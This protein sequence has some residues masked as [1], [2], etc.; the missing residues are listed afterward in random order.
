MVLKFD[1]YKFETFNSH[2]VPVH[3]KNYPWANGYVYITI[4]IGVGARHDPIGGEGTAHHFEHMPFNGCAGWE[5]HKEVQRV[6]RELFSETLNASTSHEGTKFTGK[7][8]IHNLDEAMT[9]LY[10]F[11]F[12]PMVTPKAVAREK[13]VITQEFWRRYDNKKKEALAKKETSLSYGEHAYGRAESA[14][15]WYDTI[16]QI[17]RKNLLDFHREFY[18]L[19]NTQIVLAGDVNIGRKLESAISFFTLNCP[20]TGVGVPTPKDIVEWPLPEVPQLIVSSK[21]YFGLKGDSLPNKTSIDVVRHLPASVKGGALPLARMLLRKL[22]YEKIRI[23]LSAA[24]SPN[25]SESFARDHSSLNI[26]LEIEPSKLEA[27]EEIING[28]LDEVAHGRTK[29]SILFEDMKRV[30]LNGIMFADCS[31]GKFS[32]GA[33]SELTTSGKIEPLEESY[34]NAKKVTYKD[35]SA[36]ISRE[37]TPEKLFW[38]IVTP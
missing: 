32:V 9:F 12:Q 22:L 14:L 1:P 7:V 15:G 17:S 18:T 25:V 28:I 36:L 29:H 16:T 27:V 6:N 10:H 35:I 20:N 23:A 19:A 11:I 5:S 8:A 33:S 26:T 21:E 34:A 24:Y 3:V 30:Y 37:F 38:T 4:V 2:G 31:V 13:K